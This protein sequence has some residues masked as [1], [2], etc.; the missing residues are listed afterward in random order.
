MKIKD[1]RSRMPNLTEWWDNLTATVESTVEYQIE[2]I[3]FNIAIQ[4]QKRIREMNLAQ[5]DL[6][7]KLG[8]SKS[9]VSQLL[10]GKSNMTL[11]TLIKVAN[12]LGL[13]PE[14]NLSPVT[15]DIITVED[16]VSLAQYEE[17]TVLISEPAW[18]QVY[19]GTTAYI[20][21]FAI[22]AARDTKDA[23]TKMFISNIISD[24][25][26]KSGYYRDENYRC[27]AV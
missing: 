4:I 6:A 10:K 20:K 25:G 16:E 1:G 8:V 26:Q 14:I 21:D 15:Y 23:P 7:K 17:P 24:E 22:L 5:K 11:E 12:V 27:A 9:Y 19:A 13:K 2:S 18:I 3:A